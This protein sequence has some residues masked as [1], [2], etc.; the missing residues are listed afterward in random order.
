MR[1]LPFPLHD[2]LGIPEPT[3]TLLL[4]RGLPGAGKTTLARTL[5]EL[6]GDRHLVAMMAAD[7]F[8][9]GDD[10]VYRFDAS[11]LSEAHESCRQKTEMAMG[12][13]I[14]LVIVHNTFSRNWEMAA[15]RELAVEN[16]Y[17]LTVVTVEGDHG[18]EHAPASVRTGMAARW[19]AWD[20]AVPIPGGSPTRKA[21]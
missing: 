2:R 7:D 9:V 16:D 10:G 21:S 13:G 5:L 11:R 3:P 14:P 19:E 18:S 4:L 15:Y 8:F 6:T 1:S 20:S 17:R 12:M